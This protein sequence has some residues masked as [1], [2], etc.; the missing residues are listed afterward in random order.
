M[1]KRADC[2]NR[3]HCS[4][5]DADDDTADYHDYLHGSRDRL[6]VDVDVV[7][8]IV[9]MAFL[10]HPWCIEHGGVDYAVVSEA[11]PNH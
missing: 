10:S 1:S 9:N 3:Y 6:T 7:S 5:H 11:L 4:D 2:D 8:I